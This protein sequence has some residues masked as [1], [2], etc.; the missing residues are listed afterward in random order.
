MDPILDFLLASCQPVHSTTPIYMID[1]RMLVSLSFPSLLAHGEA[2]RKVGQAAVVVLVTKIYFKMYQE[3]VLG[4]QR[5]HLPFSTCGPKETNSH[6][7]TLLHPTKHAQ[8]LLWVYGQPR[9]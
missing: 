7:S 8:D 5:K 6:A 3:G 2:A 9:V 1:F 4:V